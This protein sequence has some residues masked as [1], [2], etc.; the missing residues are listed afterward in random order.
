MPQ[1]KNG[2]ASGNHHGIETQKA[3]KVK[4][5]IPSTERDAHA[6]LECDFGQP[7]HKLGFMHCIFV[8]RAFEFT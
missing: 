1:R 8:S 3:G 4:S 6:W 7:M 2:G 5:Y